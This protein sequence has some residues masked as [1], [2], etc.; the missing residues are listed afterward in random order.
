MIL[1]RVPGFSTSSNGRKKTAFVSSLAFFWS[2]AEFKN[3][4][5]NSELKE[6]VWN[7]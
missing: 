2:S 5:E 7:S 3:S 6:L 4:T 1:D